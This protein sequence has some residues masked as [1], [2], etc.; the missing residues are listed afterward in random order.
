[1]IF[2]LMKGFSYKIDLPAVII[3][4]KKMFGIQSTANT[5]GRGKTSRGTFSLNENLAA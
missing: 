1:M 4:G 5:H 2:F 3:R